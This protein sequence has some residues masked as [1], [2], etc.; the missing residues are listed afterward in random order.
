MIAKSA[1]TALTN[2]ANSR[3]HQEIVAAS[4]TGVPTVP[5]TQLNPYGIGYTPSLGYLGGDYTGL[6]SN[7]NLD[8]SPRVGFS[9]DA[10]G[11]GRFVVRGGYGLYFG[12]T[13]ENIPLFMIQQ[14]NAQV[15]ANTYS[16]NCAGPTD[17]TCAPSNV[18]PG[19]DI[20]LSNYRY[21]VD[22]ASASSHR[23]ASIWRPVQPDGSW[24]PHFAIRTPS[25]LTLASSTP[26][27]TTASSKSSTSRPAASMKTRPST[28]T[29]PSTST[30]ASGPSQL[31]LLLR[32]FRFSAASV[33]KSRSAAPTMMPSTSVTA[34]NA[35][36]L[37]HHPELHLLQGPGF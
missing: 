30:A 5:T 33:S 22:P 19:T 4:K 3:T 6:P 14:A 26:S 11:N 32:V 7:D 13:F 21:G 37:Q 9:F 31:H 29:R 17:K 27:P 34:S 24:I 18:V 25:R 36:P 20:L 28:L 10:L 15:F 23:Q 16:I 1:H 8:F 12:Q 35:P 2:R